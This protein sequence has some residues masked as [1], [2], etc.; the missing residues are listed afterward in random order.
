MSFIEIVMKPILE[1]MGLF[2]GKKVSVKEAFEKYLKVCPQ[3]IGPLGV[4]KGIIAYKFN[5]T[6]KEMRVDGKAVDLFFVYKQKDNLFDYDP[7]L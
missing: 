3:G 7:R 2:K 6:V 1:G 5:L 4:F